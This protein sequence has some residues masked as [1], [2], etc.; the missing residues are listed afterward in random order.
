MAVSR[1]CDHDLLKMTVLCNHS[2]LPLSVSYRPASRRFISLDAIRRLP[3]SIHNRIPLRNILDS[4][5]AD[6]D[7]VRTGW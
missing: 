1:Q 4:I 7:P 5:K 3:V 2:I 6:P